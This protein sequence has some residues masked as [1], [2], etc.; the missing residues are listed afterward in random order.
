[1][2]PLPV[3]GADG[4]GRGEKGGVHESR[5]AQHNQQRSGAGKPCQIHHSRPRKGGV[6]T[7]SARH[8]GYHPKDEGEEGRG[9]PRHRGADDGG[10]RDTL[11]SASP[12]TRGGR[13]AGTNVPSLDEPPP[14]SSAMVVGGGG[15][16][17]RRH[18]VRVRCASEGEGGSLWTGAVN[19]GADGWGLGGGGG[20]DPNKAPP[21]RE[22]GVPRGVFGNKLGLDPQRSLEFRTHPSMRRGCAS[23][24][25]RWA[26]HLCRG[27]IYGGARVCHRCHGA[28]QLAK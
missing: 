18:G 2:E 13:R 15:G 16:R 23:G 24:D 12:T 3:E 22:R 17:C 27:S 14:S 19:V 1:M 10:R 5:P 9:P 26:S 28:P 25:V 21:C 6:P 20:S 7:Q 4:G 8:R 11:R